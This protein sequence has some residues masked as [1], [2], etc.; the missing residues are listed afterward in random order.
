[1]VQDDETALVVLPLG[2][3]RMSAGPEALE[4]SLAA[5]DR[6]SLARRETVVAQHLGRFALREG[7]IALA[8]TRAWEAG[9]IAPSAMRIKARPA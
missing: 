8:W 7:E 5:A 9:R 2:P 1:M 3:C 6:A 4:L